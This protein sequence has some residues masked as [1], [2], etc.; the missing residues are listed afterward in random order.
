MRRLGRKRSA[1]FPLN[2]S[3]AFLLVQGA[4]EGRVRE[5]TLEEQGK[6]H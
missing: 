2:G 3:L 6:P 1:Q 4:G 5:A